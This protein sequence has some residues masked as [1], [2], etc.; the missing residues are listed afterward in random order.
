MPVSVEE[1]GYSLLP[2]SYSLH[3]NYPNPFNPSTTIEFTLPDR[4]HIRLAV[5]NVIGQEVATLIDEEVSAGTHRTT[6][7]ASGLPSGIYF[8]RIEA[9]SDRSV[10]ANAFTATKKMVL[11]R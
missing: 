2:A 9:H 7:D 6:W 1:D 3:Q 10:G 4:S 11:L 8:V 5:Y